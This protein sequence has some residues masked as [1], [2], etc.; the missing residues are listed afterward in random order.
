M[1]QP[2]SK[3]VAFGNRQSG[4]HL[5]YLKVFANSDRQI[6]ATK[7]WKIQGKWTIIARGFCYRFCVVVVVFHL[8]VCLSV[9]I[10]S[11]ACAFMYPECKQCKNCELQ[12]M[13]VDVEQESRRAG[14]E[15]EVGKASHALVASFLG[16]VP[17]VW[18]RT[19]VSLWLLVFALSVAGD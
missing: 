2:Q 19:A 3:G 15:Q 9:S 1:Q 8:S 13:E 10:R 4:V 11:A 5:D 16:S 17:A 6:C 7:P 12:R 14:G 18:S